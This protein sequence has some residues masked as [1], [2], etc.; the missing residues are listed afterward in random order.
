MNKDSVKELLGMVEEYIDIEFDK[1]KK[2]ETCPNEG[3]ELAKIR[4]FSEGQ[5]VRVGDQYVTLNRRIEYDFEVPDGSNMFQGMI[6]LA[7]K[8]MEAVSELCI[9]IQK[10]AKKGVFVSRPLT[11]KCPGGVDNGDGTFSYS[12]AD[13]DLKPRPGSNTFVIGGDKFWLRSEER[14][15]SRKKSTIIEIDILYGI[16]E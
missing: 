12:A 13:F 5:P 11:S 10:A 3:D 15:D 4:S 2:E 16:L 8:Y 9:L 6:I 1:G 7:N 14:Y